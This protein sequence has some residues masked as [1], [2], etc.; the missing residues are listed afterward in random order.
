[1]ISLLDMN[2]KAFTEGDYV[3]FADGD[4]RLRVAEVRGIKETNRGHRL[5]LEIIHG[6]MVNRKRYSRDYF[7]SDFYKIEKEDA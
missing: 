7:T 6:R 4:G 2:G 3:L 1:M 5:A